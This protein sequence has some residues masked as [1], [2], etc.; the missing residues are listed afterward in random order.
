VALRSYPLLS[1]SG[2][3]LFMNAAITFVIGVFITTAAS[4]LPAWQ[5]ASIDPS[6]VMT[7]GE[8]D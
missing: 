8:Y 2:Y 5:A 4:V 7:K 1:L 6:S 3:E